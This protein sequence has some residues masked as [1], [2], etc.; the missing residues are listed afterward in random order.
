MNAEKK[1]EAYIAATALLEENPEA[2]LRALEA[3]ED[4]YED[5][6]NAR[7][8]AE[9]TIA[10]RDGE[11]ISA[12]EQI[13]KGEDPDSTIALLKSLR[14]LYP[15]E[16]DQE[17]IDELIRQANQVKQETEDRKAEEQKNEETL[18]NAREEISKGTKESIQKGIDI[19]KQLKDESGYNVDEEIIIDAEE[20]LKSVLQKEKEAEER[21]EAE[22]KAA[23][24]AEARRK[25]EAEAAAAEKAREEE[26]RKGAEEAQ[27]LLEKQDYDGAL[28][29]LKLVPNQGDGEIIRLTEE[30]NNGNEKKKRFQEGKNNV[31]EA[32][33][34]FQLSKDNRGYR[35]ELD[36]LRKA[37]EEYEE[38]AECFEW[39]VNDGGFSLEGESAEDLKE[40]CEGMGYYLEGRRLMLETT[41]Y[42]VAVYCFEQVPDDLT[43]DVQEQLLQANRALKLRDAEE[44]FNGGYGDLDKAWQ[45]YTDL[46]VYDQEASEEGLAKVKTARE[47]TEKYKQADL[48]AQKMDSLETAKTLFAELVKYDGGNGWQDSGI[49]LTETEKLLNKKEKLDSARKKMSGDGPEGGVPSEENCRGAKELYI[50]LMNGYTFDGTKRY[51]QTDREIY[52]AA[53]A[54]CEDCEKLLQAYSEYHQAAAAIA[55]DMDAAY[56]TLCRVRDGGIAEAKTETDRIER[57][58]NAKKTMEEARQQMETEPVPAEE[59]YETALRDFETLKNERFPGAENLEQ[60]C[61][62]ERDYIGA[63]NR[64]K[65]DPE[66]AKDV[67]DHLGNEFL[68]SKTYAQQCEDILRYRK[69]RELL[70]R[71]E[72]EKDYVEALNQLNGMNDCGYS[73]DGGQKASEMICECER[74]LFCRDADGSRAP[75]LMRNVLGWIYDHASGPEE[76]TRRAEITRAATGAELA[77][78]IEGMLQN[79]ITENSERIRI[80]CEILLNNPEDPQ[81]GEY[82]ED[83]DNGMSMN[84]VL[85][86][87]IHRGE[88]AE[89]C[90]EM[91]TGE[92]EL[93]EDRDRNPD[94]TRFVTHCFRTALDRNPSAGDLNHH[95]ALILNGELTMEGLM[96]DFAC[97]EDCREK[98]PEDPAFVG[99]LYRLLFGRNASEQEVSHYLGDE[100][101]G[102]GKKREELAGIL[103]N[104][105]DCR[106]Y[107][108]QFRPELN[109]YQIG[110][111]LEDFTASAASG[112]PVSIP[113]QNACEFI[114]N[115]QQIPAQKK[116]EWAASLMP[117][118][119]LHDLIYS[120][121]NYP[122][123]SG[124]E[125]SNAERVAAVYRIMLNRR[126]DPNTDPGSSQFL[127]AMETGM[128]MDYLISSIAGSIEF[129]DQCQSLGMDPGVFTSLDDLEPMDRNAELTALVDEC[130]KTGL[131]YSGSRVDYNEWCGR[132]WNQVPLRE[133]LIQFLTDPN[134]Q[135]H[136]ADNDSFI[137]ALYQIALGRPA[138]ENGMMA[139]MERLNQGVDRGTTAREVVLA[140]QE[141]Y[142]HWRPTHLL[143]DE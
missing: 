57:F 22:K 29:K 139:C 92:V 21:K 76:R 136:L 19:L 23:E 7:K 97:K 60:E 9:E 124:T 119:T 141:F 102:S 2:A 132:Y 118:S 80:L 68:K 84:Y 113:A 34:F 110:E 25:A 103:I 65:T 77:S 18:K 100:F 20:K 1:K 128:S 140:S 81:A 73:E 42:G 39:L 44:N 50:S 48:A 62:N 24:E 117:D 98:Y 63:V 3:F 90:G 30:A 6:G 87:I 107:L 108:L 70:G 112:K 55:E 10:R 106:N 69:A 114:Y 122:A 56:E 89:L 127:K 5:T 126:V 75:Q 47:N 26:T 16:E 15:K 109:E 8:R 59:K 43:E 71:T 13:E 67:F 38:A 115:L 78:E 85:N 32:D 72:S 46:A 99:M 116:R 138:D 27:V 123:F 35:D 95:C 83:L 143:R 66:A 120:F 142:E 134:V 93:T 104:T 52:D 105:S 64:I 37:K 129:N 101:L 94:V 12:K 131:G 49:C 86:R 54:E 31:S 130:Y 36:F 14:K 111:S 137:R 11:F 45:D 91:E 135:A 28:Q 51:P 17:K 61:R 41:A 125:I 53:K 74:E 58:R 88:F 33:L 82:A 133:I 96:L 4:G 40:K 121:V 79:N